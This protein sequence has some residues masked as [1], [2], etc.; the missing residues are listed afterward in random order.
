MHERGSVEV[1]HVGRYYEA[2]DS[3]ENVAASTKTHVTSN[4]TKPTCWH[5]KILMLHQN[6][7][8]KKCMRRDRVQQGVRDPDVYVIVRGPVHLD[9]RAL[10]RVGVGDARVEVGAAGSPIGRGRTP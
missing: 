5:W 1:T 7:V 4:R 2:S 8:L 10:R 9:H 3:F 6:V